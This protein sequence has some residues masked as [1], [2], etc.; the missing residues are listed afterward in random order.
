MLSGVQ[1]N[2]HAALEKSDI[3]HLIGERNICDHIS[4]AV[5][6]ANTIVRDHNALPEWRRRGL[7]PV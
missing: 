4:K 5:S 6:L 2:V 3:V 7:D 1:P